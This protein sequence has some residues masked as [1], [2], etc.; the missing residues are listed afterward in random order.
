MMKFTSN[1]PDKRGELHHRFSLSLS[2]SPSLSLSF[3]L[4]LSLSL[5]LLPG[6]N[7]LLVWSLAQFDCEVCLRNSVMVVFFY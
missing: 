1:D 7:D 2:L 4:S 6:Q 3:S 5:S